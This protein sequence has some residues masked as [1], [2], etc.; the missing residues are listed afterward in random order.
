MQFIQGKG[1]LVMS[2]ILKVKLF[3]AL[4]VSFIAFCIALGIYLSK[5]DCCELISDEVKVDAP[6]VITKENGDYKGIPDKYAEEF[7]SNEIHR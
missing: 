2:K 3:I 4:I 6:V 7:C 1:R 5:G